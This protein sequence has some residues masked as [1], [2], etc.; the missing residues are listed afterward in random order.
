MYVWKSNFNDNG[1]SRLS[2]INLDLFAILN[3]VVIGFFFFF[4]FFDEKSNGCIRKCIH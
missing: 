3:I 2:H 1:S 4:F